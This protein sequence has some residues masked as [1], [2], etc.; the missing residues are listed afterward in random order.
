MDLTSPARRYDP[1]VVVSLR[2]VVTA[3]LVA[4]VSCR[5][6]NRRNV[7]TSRALVPLQGRWHGMGISIWR[8]PADAH[9]GQVHVM[10]PK[11]APQPTREVS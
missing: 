1:T 3:L 7:R 2:T 6:M 11:P 8:S 4:E 9:D 10:M 5:L